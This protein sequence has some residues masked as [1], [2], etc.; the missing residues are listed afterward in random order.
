MPT[1]A[2]FNGASPLGSVSSICPGPTVPRKVPH[3]PTLWAQYQSRIRTWRDPP[4][5]SCAWR[6]EAR[7][8][9]APAASEAHRSFESGW[10]LTLQAYLHRSVVERVWTRYGACLFSG[11]HGK[12]AFSG[13]RPRVEGRHRHEAAAAGEV[14]PFESGGS[15]AT[16]SGPAS[17]GP[18]SS[19]AR[20]T[21]GQPS[22]LPD[23]SDGPFLAL[24]A[25][26]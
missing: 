2:R 26:A 20:A 3:R 21:R 18:S 15:A 7:E 1:T 13:A 6:E 14:I 4:R 10:L 9:G 22:S 8:Q 19:A 16:A 25:A 5:C 11:Y 17:S 12:P 23:R 24:S